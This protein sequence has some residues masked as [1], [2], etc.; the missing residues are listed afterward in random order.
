MQVKTTMR[1]HLTPVR[2]VIIKKTID[3]KC[4]CGCGE[5][6][7]LVLCWWERQL[8][9]PLWKRVWKFIKKLKIELP[10]G[11]AILCLGGYPK[12]MKTL[13]EKDNCCPMFIEALLTIAKT[14]KQP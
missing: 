3:K 4:W 11:P 12:E 6:G 10:Y 5:K 13:T 1:Y 14:R 9:Q 2:M 7:I 8:G